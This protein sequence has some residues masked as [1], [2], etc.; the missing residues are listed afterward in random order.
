MSS[1]AALLALLVLPLLAVTACSGDDNHRPPGASPTTADTRPLP[2]RVHVRKR[3]DGVTLGDPAFEALRGARVVLRGNLT[4]D[5]QPFDARFLGAVVR[6]AGLVT[7]CQLTLP[8]VTGGRYTI[9]VLADAESRGCGARDAEILLWAF[10]D[11][12]I[13]YS[14]G[15]VPWPGN[16]RT[17][18]FDASFSTATPNG[19]VPPTVQFNGE[20]FGRDGTTLPQGTRVEAYV[21]TTRCGIAS[22]RRSGSF[23][24]YVLAVVGPE[25]ISGCLRGAIIT[26]RIEGRPA[27]ETSRNDPSVQ[28]VALDLTLR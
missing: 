6:R 28:G 4:L 22:T 13:H 26:F 16:G 12:K 20:L 18:T 10:V 27:V 17:A 24:G 8:P 9:T 1:R 3:P 15:A 5:G 21:G 23:A 14:T 11:D 2:P 19:D 7:P 25:S